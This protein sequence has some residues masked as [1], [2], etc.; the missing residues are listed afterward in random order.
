MDSAPA[1]RVIDTFGVSHFAAGPILPA[2]VERTLTALETPSRRLWAVDLGDT[3]WSVLSTPTDT[4]TLHLVWPAGAEDPL[5]DFAATV[6][7]AAAILAH[8]SGAGR[9][10]AGPQYGAPPVARPVF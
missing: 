4:A 8:F 3:Q 10:G 7:F 5:L 6:D 1:L 9:T 2:V